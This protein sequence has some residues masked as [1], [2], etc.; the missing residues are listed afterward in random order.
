MTTEHADFAS[1]PGPATGAARPA[2]PETV[3][4]SRAPSRGQTRRTGGPHGRRVSTQDGDGN[5]GPTST[6]RA[7][8]MSEIYG[9]AARLFAEKGL[10]GTSLQ[11]IADATGFSRQALYH[12][13]KSKDELFEHLV[14]EITRSPATELRAINART[15]LDAR[16]KLRAITRALATHRAEHPHS[17]LL[18]VRS[19]AD[20]PD[21]LS[22]EHRHGKR[23][24]LHEIVRAVEAGQRSGQFRQVD[25]GIASLSILGMI[26]WIAWWFNPEGRESADAVGEQVADLAVAVVARSANSSRTSTEPEAVFGDLRE[27]LDILEHAY[28]EALHTAQSRTGDQR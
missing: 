27:S 24:V 4:G 20:L 14:T 11:D 13:V 26:N 12:Y 28:R 22:S 19:E 8:V 23:A 18:A 17:F 2:A 10:A 5:N 1:S 16:D 15:D 7:L 9:Q 25:P 3:P 21:E 6:R